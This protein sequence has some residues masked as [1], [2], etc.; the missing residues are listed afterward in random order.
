MESSTL[1][2]DEE[3]VAMCIVIFDQIASQDCGHYGALANSV[4]AIQIQKN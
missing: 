4:G 1:R 2:W 3:F